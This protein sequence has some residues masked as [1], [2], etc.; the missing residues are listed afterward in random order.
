MSFSRSAASSSEVGRSPRAEKQVD[1]EDQHV[2]VELGIEHVVERGVGG[3]A[4]VPIM[5]AVDDHRG[6]AGRQRAGG[7]DVLRA[8]FLAEL[9][10]LVIVEIF[11]VAGGDADR[12]DRQAGLQV[13][14]AVEID[15]AL[16][17]LL[18]GR[19]VVIAL[20][21]GMPR[22][23]QRRRRD[24]RDEEAGHAEGGDQ[25]GTGRV[26]QLA[27][28][29]ALADRFPRHRRGD[30]F[31]EFLKPL[32][33]GR[34]LV[35]GDDGGV[36]RTDRDARDPFRLEA[37][38]AQRL[39]GARLVRAERA[40]ALQDQDALRMRGDAG[41]FRAT[42][43]HRGTLAMAR[44]RGDTSRRRQCMPGS[45]LAHRSV[46]AR[47]MVQNTLYLVPGA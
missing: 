23:P 47:I 20:G 31:P 40:A 9:L 30:H 44:H 16:Q 37:G 11:E 4:A 32:D 19:R 10:E 39:I 18:Q 7:H 17:R 36:D 1:L 8:D 21:F 2:A 15:Q 14:D 43:C 35:A 42:I 28:V 25:R 13:V 34:P 46:E 33:A 38:A 27:A 5:L 45:S 41:G 24:A 3:D 22:R 12:A 26:E 6:K 29:I